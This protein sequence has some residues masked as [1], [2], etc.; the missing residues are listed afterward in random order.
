MTMPPLHHGQGE[1]KKRPPKRTGAIAERKAGLVMK[2]FPRTVCARV[3]LRDNVPGPAS[4]PR[5]AI[6]N[7]LPAPPGASREVP[8]RKA[9]ENLARFP[10]TERQRRTG[11]S[12]RVRPRFP[13]A[14][15][16]QR[17]TGR[18][19]GTEGTNADARTPNRPPTERVNRE[20]ATPS[21]RTAHSCAANSAATEPTAA[22]TA[23]AGIGFDGEN[24]NGSDDKRDD[25]D[26]AF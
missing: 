10:A 4:E 22:H 8:E 25:A 3:T 9:C 5:E 16:R 14:A 17:R 6:T 20:S 1:P 26:T 19:G 2:R 24:S 23:T 11:R 7:R 18:S 21:D 12:A 13:P 15:E